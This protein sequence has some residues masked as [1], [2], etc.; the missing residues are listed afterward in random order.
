MTPATAG[1]SP[2]LTG[3]TGGNWDRLGVRPRT[4]RSAAVWFAA[5]VFG[6]SRW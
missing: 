3:G 5:C 2:V 1:A 4:R 6:A